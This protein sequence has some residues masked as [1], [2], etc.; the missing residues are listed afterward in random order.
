MDLS[1][2]VQ[3]GTTDYD[4]RFS[5]I[6]L[7]S[8][9]LAAG[10]VIYITDRGWNAP[11]NSFLDNVI[12]S[13][14]G[15]NVGSEAVIKWVVPAGGI[16]QGTEVYFISHYNSATSVQSWTAHSDE[17]GTTALGVVTPETNSSVDGG[18]GFT[19]AGDEILV[20]QTGV[21]AGPA[22]AYNAT[23]IRFITALMANIVAN[24]TTYPGWDPSP[25]TLSESSLPPG[26]TNGIS[27]FIMSPGPLPNAVANTT[28]EPDNG[29]YSCAGFTGS[30]NATTIS[31]A[32]YTVTNWTFNAAAFPIGATSSDCN[33]LPGEI[34]VKGNT[35]SIVDGDV[36]PSATDHTDFGNANSGGGNVIRTFTIENSGTTSITVSGITMSGADA[37]LFTVG[38]L[39]PASPIPPG[40]SA[41]FTVTFTPTTLGLKTATVN[42]ANNDCNET[43]YD[44][45]VQGTGT[46]P[47]FAEI[48]TKGN[49]VSIVDGDVTPSLT[50]H[51]DFG[52]ANTGGGNVVRTFTIENTGSGNLTVTAITMSGANAS[53]FT[54]GALT[55]ASPIP[56]GA[57]QHLP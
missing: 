34:N 36:T 49:T 12:V 13:C 51:T 41:T 25:C 31:T 24:S 42:I 54:V 47:C 32:I 4:D 17:A 2:V 15:T 44:Y 50:D 43:T 52:N 1:N 7:K 33:V 57:Q 6:I 26:L 18:M 8:G 35:V 38:A 3:G 16:P 22:G 55:P 5:M 10:T 28:T 48:N 14:S 9:G 53:L 30:C 45:A 46:T 39:T 23:P 21:A 19:V 11:T 27:A 56:A 29:K 40:G 20:Y 37:A